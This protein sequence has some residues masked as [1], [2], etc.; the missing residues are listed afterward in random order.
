CCN[1]GLQMCFLCLP[2]E[3]FVYSKNIKVII[4]KYHHFYLS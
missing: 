1:Y 4:H 2:S 3:S